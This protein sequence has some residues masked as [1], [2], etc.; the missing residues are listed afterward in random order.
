[1]RT[2]PRLRNSLLGCAVTLIATGPVVF[3]V[4]NGLAPFGL[5]GHFT[6][7]GDGVQFDVGGD[8]P[9]L[10]WA[11]LACAELAAPVIA[12]PA[13]VLLRIAITELARRRLDSIWLS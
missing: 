1:M 6:C 2:M 3:A 13:I 9:N 11:D 12:L 5:S 8:A 4:A 7:D 10:S